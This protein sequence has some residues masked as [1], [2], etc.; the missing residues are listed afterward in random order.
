MTKYHFISGLPR[1]GSTLLTSILNQNPKF[2]STI[3]NPLARFVKS[4]VIETFAGPGYSIECPE[5]KRMKLIKNLIETYHE[6]YDKE[7]C[8]NT[9]RGWSLLLPMLDQTFPDAKL[10]CCVRDIPW[11][12]DSFELLFRKNPF[13]HS[14]LFTDQ[15]RET[16]Y[17]RANSLMSPGNSLRFPYDSLKEAI[18][19][20]HKHKI[21]LL[22]YEQLTTKPEETMR[23]LYNFI[24]EDYY[25]HDFDNVET[26]YDEYD[27][28]AGINGLHKIRKKVQYIPRE[29]IL[30]PDV[31]HQFSG[32]EV[33][34]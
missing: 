1:S 3:S 30:P 18:T 25:N 17:T 26:S 15:D 20:P 7:V 24:G 11:I 29:T 5:P 8:F 13:T 14:R 9:N 33:W 23:S 27:A 2:H 28:A 32:L 31:F 16:V 12:L 6:D 4:V 19:G 22:E 21:F 34:R 10:I